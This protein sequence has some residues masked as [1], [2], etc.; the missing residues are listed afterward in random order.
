MGSLKSLQD[1]HNKN[2][3]SQTRLRFVV[4]LAV[5]LA[6]FSPLMHVLLMV[7]G[8]YDAYGSW[9]SLREGLRVRM[10]G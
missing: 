1:L 2:K 8:V 6:N 4:C 7:C 5:F 3:S 10:E 9:C